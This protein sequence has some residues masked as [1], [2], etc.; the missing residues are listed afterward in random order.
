MGIV[1]RVRCDELSS[2]LLQSRPVSARFYLALEGRFVPPW[3]VKIVR[4]RPVG[5]VVASADVPNDPDGV[6]RSTPVASC[7][8]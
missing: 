8:R 5:C 6:F 2:A 4:V 7:C 1:V 3:L